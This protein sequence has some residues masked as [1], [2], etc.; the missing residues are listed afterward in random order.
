[1]LYISFVKNEI[2]QY[3]QYVYIFDENSDDK[4]NSLVLLLPSLY[5][6]FFFFFTF[7]H[8]ALYRSFHN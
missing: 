8:F 6:F 4:N 3:G 7:L 5:F 2:Y 1:M